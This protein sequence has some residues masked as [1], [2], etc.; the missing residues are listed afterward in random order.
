MNLNGINFKD[1]IKR[2]F[3]IKCLL[4]V[5]LILI[6][7]N[8]Y[9]VDSGFAQLSDYSEIHNQADA[10]RQKAGFEEYSQGEGV[11]KIIA[12]IIKGFLSLLGV[13]FIILILIGGYNWMTAAGEEEKIK[14]AK[15]TLRRAIIGLLIV[16]SAYA[17]TYFVFTYLPWGG[18]G[19]PV[20][21]S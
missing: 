8:I 12:I 9:F 13:I 1:M 6:F 14:K 21:G 5:G 20:G 7:I 15:D 18:G 2:K 10:L 16:V 17:I 4:I 19:S 11:G 3:K